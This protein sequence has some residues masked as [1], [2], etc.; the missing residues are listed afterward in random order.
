MQEDEKIQSPHCKGES[1]V[2]STATISQ[3][4]PNCKC[5]ARQSPSLKMWFAFIGGMRVV[6]V[7]AGLLGWWFGS[8][9]NS[10]DRRSES[11]RDGESAEPCPDNAETVTLPDDVK[12]IT[13]PGGARMEL[14]WCPPGT[15][16]MGSPSYEV[17]R[18]ASEKQHCVTLTK[19]FWM[20]KYEVTQRQWKSVMGDNP[21]DFKGDDLP[22]ENVSWNDCQEFIRKVRESSGLDVSLPTEAQW[23]Y[24]CRA[25]SKGAYCKLS[26]GAE[27]TDS[28]LGDA[29]WHDGNS[30]NKTHSVGLKKPNAFGLYDMH[31]NVWE[32]CQDLYGEYEGDATDPTGLSSGSLRVLR[33]GGW[34]SYAR[35]CRS[36]NRNGH[37][38]GIRYYFNG[39][40]LACS[41]GPRGKGVARGGNAAQAERAASD[42]RASVMSRRGST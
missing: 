7:L 28:T 21:S 40:R 8:S 13:L 38:P 36:A 35:N 2:E 32:W 9:R 33:G 30:E 31:G 20:G 37:S 22:V 12:T 15:F 23:E 10:K 29:A 11:R 26:D 39:F 17:G 25:G 18:F 16:T 24:A 19:G 42:T 14:V 27:V 34:G 4:S 5:N 41:A 6:G 3:E 1:E